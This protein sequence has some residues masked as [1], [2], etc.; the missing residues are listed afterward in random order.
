M[1][2]RLRSSWGSRPIPWNR[3]NH[4]NCRQ[5]SLRRLLADEVQLRAQCNLAKAKSFRALRQKTM[6]RYRNRTLLGA[7][8]IQAWLSRQ[9]R[10]QVAVQKVVIGVSRD[11]LVIIKKT[12]RYGIAAGAS[13]RCEFVADSWRAASR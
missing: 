7:F 13:R 11:N 4:E 6:D 1:P 9:E 5:V 2:S 10:R 12:R 8:Q 3:K